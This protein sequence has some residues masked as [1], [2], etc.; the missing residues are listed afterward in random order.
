MEGSN[1][2]HNNLELLVSGS[3]STVSREERGVNGT[4]LLQAVSAQ[5]WREVRKLI[6]G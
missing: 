4:D 1:N 6:L 5:N 2:V 3:N